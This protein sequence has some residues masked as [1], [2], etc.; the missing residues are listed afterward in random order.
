[1]ENIEIRNI[2]IAGIVGVLVILFAVI[3]SFTLNLELIEN[4]IMSWILTTFYGVFALFL[5]RNEFY[6][7]RTVEIETPI[8]I[9]RP[10]IHEIIR[11]VNVPIQIPVENKT[12]EVVEKP[13]IQRVEVPVYRN[14]NV[15]IEKK[16][17]KINPIHFNYIAS[18]E[19]KR[20]HT[21]FCRL[22]KLIKNKFK[23]HDNNQSYFIKKHFKACKVCILHKKKI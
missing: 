17:E 14:R 9:D 18:S 6:P 20:F 22:G 8:Y 5:V 2:L 23:I 10:V 11:E 16:R 4:L 15:Y 21:R 1:M 3:T 13:V 7:Q 12:I 19:A